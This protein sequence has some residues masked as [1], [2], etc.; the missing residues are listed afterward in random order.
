MPNL[1]MLKII[2]RETLSRGR[3]ERT[4]EPSLVMDDEDQ[5]QAYVAAGRETGV[6]A[7]TYVFHGA[8]ISDVIKP[9]DR[10]LDLACGPANQLALVARLNP[11]VSFVGIDLS[12]SMLA[13]AEAL[14]AAQELD[15]VS[16]QQGDITCLS[17]FADQSFDAVISTLSLHH[18]PTTG[19]LAQTFAEA[20]RVLRPNGGVYIMDFSRLKARSSIEYFAYQYVD[21]QPALFTQDYLNSLLAAFTLAELKAAG[22]PLI[23]RATLFSTWGVPFMASFKSPLRQPANPKLRAL[24]KELVEALPAWHQTDLADMVRFFRMGGLQ[25]ALLA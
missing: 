22:A 9:G 13:Q 24:F 2:V 20:A 14:I 8:N 11:D 5:V 23:G 7:P 17:A 21:R 4:P 6:M 15:N 25:S 18:L 3:I 19:M 1:S 12:P 16:F 10:V